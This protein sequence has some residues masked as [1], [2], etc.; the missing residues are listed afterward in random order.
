M[1]D[2]G[3][4]CGESGFFQVVCPCCTVGFVEG[5]CDGCVSFFEDVLDALFGGEDVE[6]F[7]V[8]EI[9]FWVV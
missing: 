3:V 9:D 2:F 6:L 8:F 1:F 4:W 7:S 5:C